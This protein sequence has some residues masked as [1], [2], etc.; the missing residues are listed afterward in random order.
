MRSARDGARAIGGF[1]HVLYMKS[2]R[3]PPLLPREPNPS[4]AYSSWTHYTSI[5]L[6]LR[7]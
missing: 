7:S 5:L 4:I 1:V 6:L 2:A 3:A